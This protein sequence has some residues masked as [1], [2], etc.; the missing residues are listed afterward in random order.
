MRNGRLYGRLAALAA[1]AGALLAFALACSSDPAPPP[2]PDGGG[3]ASPDGGGGGSPYA[4]EGDPDGGSK[5][6][7]LSDAT[8]DRCGKNCLPM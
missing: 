3:S 7:G 4:P 2:S 5:I 8:F 6:P 1:V